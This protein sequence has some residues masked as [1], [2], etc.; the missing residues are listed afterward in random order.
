MQYDLH[1]WGK[2]RFAP[3]V[4]GVLRAML[5][6]DCFSWGGG[7]ERR[8]YP[9][10]PPPFCGRVISAEIKNQKHNNFPH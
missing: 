10:L 5:A 6:A 2:V 1:P 7:G 9:L 4:S 8:A 3:P